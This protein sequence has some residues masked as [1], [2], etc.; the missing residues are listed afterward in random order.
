M[1]KKKTIILGDNSYFFEDAKITRAE[2]IE[3]KQELA[4]KNGAIKLESGSKVKKRIHYSL[5]SAVQ[6]MTSSINRKE[7]ESNAEK[8][9]I[10]K[11]IE[12][13]LITS[14]DDL[15]EKNSIE[16]NNI[17][18]IAVM[19]EISSTIKK[20]V[21]NKFYFSKKEIFDIAKVSTNN[22]YHLEKILN[23]MRSEN[24]AVITE[25][26]ISDDLSNIY[27]EKM[28]I[29]F[30]TGYGYRVDV[31]PSLFSSGAT[32]DISLDV[33]QNFVF[34]DLPS[35]AKIIIEIHQDF[36]P[37]LI[38]PHK[39]KYSEGYIQIFNRTINLFNF[40]HS[41]TLYK[42]IIEIKAI[43]QNRKFTYMELLKRFGS[44]FG[45]KK[46]IDPKYKP[47]MHVSKKF[48]KNIKN[49]YIFEMDRQGNILY[50]EDYLKTYRFFKKEI[51]LPAIEEINEHSEYI[52]NLIEHRE[53]NLKNSAIEFIQF[54][55]NRKKEEELDKTN[56]YLSIEKYLTAR[57]ALSNI[58]NNKEPITNLNSYANK[59][60]EII[61]K[62]G[63]AFFASK[64]LSNL[65]SLLDAEERIRTNLECINKIKKFL[66]NNY[67]ETS[68]L[69]F[70]EE[71]WVVFDKSTRAKRYGN[72]QFLYTRLGNDAI[73]CWETIESKYNLLINTS[74][75]FDSKNLTSYLNFE[76]FSENDKKF[77]TV[78]TNNIMNY[79]FEIF[80]AIKS[81]KN[82]YFKGFKNIKMKKLFME[83]FCITK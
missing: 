58:D 68:S 11:M 6:K 74:P 51:I 35:E 72:N 53:K 48:L 40:E 7:I 2:I 73:Q 3:T 23:N 46:K 77:I 57:I 4:Q 80:D 32:N 56:K 83:S 34:K 33:N 24:S 61:D 50:E 29:S 43:W 42:L 17:Y 28:M 8:I 38:N 79:E 21:P 26:K 20:I 18:K 9:V 14:Y 25:K 45:K 19:N 44:N 15:I 10:D 63:D 59:L 54:E 22:T 78:N 60:K 66:L 76:F 47:D 52:V 12:K 64:Q 13:K 36:L 75:D 39:N 70:D 81:K 55:V 41:T 5:I 37:Y 27:D 49:E 16:L 71:Y 65:S 69:W 1:A 82:K 30:I 62:E 31:E 67:K